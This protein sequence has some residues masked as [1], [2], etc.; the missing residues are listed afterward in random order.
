MSMTKEPNDKHKTFFFIFNYDLKIYLECIGKWV[1]YLLL[2]M[3][4]KS[5]LF[6][7]GSNEIYLYDM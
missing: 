1:Y 5:L 7:N 6:Y 4:S 2:S 3:K